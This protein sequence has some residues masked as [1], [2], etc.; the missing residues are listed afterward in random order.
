MSAILWIILTTFISILIYMIRLIMFN[1]T[2]I[3]FKW[4]ERYKYIKFS[5]NTAKTFRFFFILAINFEN[6]VIVTEL[7]GCL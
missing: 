2:Q 1:F 4:V 7:F 3:M 5:E 6:S